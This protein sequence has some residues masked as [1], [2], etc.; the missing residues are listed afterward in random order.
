MSLFSTKF[1]KY[2]IIHPQLKQ[3]F[4]EVPPKKKKKLVHEEISCNAYVQGEKLAR[5]GWGGAGVYSIS[6]LCEYLMTCR[7][8]KGKCV[9]A[10]PLF[11]SL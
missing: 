10:N 7:L 2:V 6:A 5:R 9:L 4:K 3:H 11:S 1:I 8:F